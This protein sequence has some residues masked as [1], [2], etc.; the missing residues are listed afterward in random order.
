MKEFSL[1]E[2]LKN[3]EREVVTR[4]ERKV[5]II[6]TDRKNHDNFPIIALVETDEDDERVRSFKIDGKWSIDG[7]ENSL[8]LFFAP[9]KHEGWIVINK[10]LDGVRD[11]NGIIYYNKLDIPDMPPVGVQ[12]VATI[13]IE[14]EEELL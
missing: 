3:P 11:T 14:W 2:Y 9:E 4:D 8:D 12:R 6:C 13:K 1:E 5:R 10:Y 7:L